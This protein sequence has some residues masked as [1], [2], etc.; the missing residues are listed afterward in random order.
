MPALAGAKPRATARVELENA[1]VATSV[2]APSGAVRLASVARKLCEAVSG[3]LPRNSAPG[4]AF[5]GSAGA[6]CDA[7]SSRTSSTVSARTRSV[8]RGERS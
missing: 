1:P 5:A 3:P 2:P 7:L 4:A 6:V 8:E